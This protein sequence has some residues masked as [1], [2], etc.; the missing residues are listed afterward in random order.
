MAAVETT[1]VVVI[2]TGFGG[3][4]PAYYLSAGGARVVM[5]DRGLH[6]GPPPRHLHT[7]RRSHQRH[8][9]ERRR[10]QLC[11]RRERRLLRRL[12]ARAELRVRAPGDARAPPLAHVDHAREPRRVLRPRRVRA[13][14]R[15][16]ELGRG[17][18]RG[19]AVGGGVCARGTHLQPAPGRRRLA[20]V[21]ELQLDAERLRL[22]RQA[23]DAPQLPAG[24]R[25][26]RDRDPAAARGAVD[27]ATR[28]PSIRSIRA[29]IAWWSRA[30]RSRRSW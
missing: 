24:G 14:G 8:G 4:I 27:R 19:R 9:H 2:G 1:D 26:V 23:L 29:T 17:V 3:A 11:R 15:A 21:H 7:H 12:A 6:A 25:D 30:A 10:R 16:A 22:R 28:C 5:R 18:V 20:A 13:A